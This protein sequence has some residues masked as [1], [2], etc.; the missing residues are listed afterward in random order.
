MN[1]D[2]AAQWLEDHG[3]DIR[4]CVWL[5]GAIERAN[6]PIDKTR[7]ILPMAWKPTGLSEKPTLLGLPVVWADVVEPYIAI[8]R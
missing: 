5:I 2:V 4:N 3:P 8:R 7:F 6:L 1:P